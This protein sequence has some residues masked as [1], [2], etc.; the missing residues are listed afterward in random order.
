MGKKNKLPNLTVAES[1]A[2]IDFGVAFLLMCVGGVYAVYHVSSSRAVRSDGNQVP[3]Y[4]K[5]AKDRREGNPGGSRAAAVLLLL[6]P[7][8]PSQLARLL[9]ELAFHELQHLHQR[10]SAGWPITRSR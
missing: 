8:G 3:V 4:F 1:K 7:H 10:S 5:Q 9:H 6:P 2:A